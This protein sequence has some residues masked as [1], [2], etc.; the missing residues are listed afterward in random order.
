MVVVVQLS[1]LV[2]DQEV[3]DR[4]ELGQADM[5]G[6]PWESWAEVHCLR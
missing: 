3:G 5:H 4:R 2:V 6:R 1:W